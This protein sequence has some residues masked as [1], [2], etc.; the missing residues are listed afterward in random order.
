MLHDD[1]EGITE[2]IRRDAELDRDTSS[3]QNLQ[4]FRNALGR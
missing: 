1:A 4:E 3:G 2:A